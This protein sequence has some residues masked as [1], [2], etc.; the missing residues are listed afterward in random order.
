MPLSLAKAQVIR[1]ATVIP[2][3]RQKKKMISMMTVKV[4]VAARDWVALSRIAIPG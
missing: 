4:I 1:D 2:L 3:T